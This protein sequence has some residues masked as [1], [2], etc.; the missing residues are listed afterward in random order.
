MIEPNYRDMSE[1]A[2][3]HA[4]LT[5]FQSLV[6]IARDHGYDDIAEVAEIAAAEKEDEIVKQEMGDDDQT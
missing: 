2:R 6:D 4:W 1:V 5:F 3:D